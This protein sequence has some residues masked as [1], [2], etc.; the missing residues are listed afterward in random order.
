MCD[1]FQGIGDLCCD[2]C[3]LFATENTGDANVDVRH[4]VFLNG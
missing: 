3:F 2:F 1:A 4:S